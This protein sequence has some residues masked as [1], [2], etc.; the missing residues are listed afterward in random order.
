MYKIFIVNVSYKIDIFTS[1]DRD[2]L[3]TVQI[4]WEISD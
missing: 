3:H 4:D 1:E 2:Q